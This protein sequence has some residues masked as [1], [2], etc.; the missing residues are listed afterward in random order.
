MKTFDVH[1]KAFRGVM[2]ALLILLAVLSATVAADFAASP[3]RFEKTIETLD[4]KKEDVMQLT[5][6]ASATSVMITMAPGDA[7]TPIAEKMAD[8]T[9]WFLLVLCAIYLEKYLVTI[10]GIVAFRVLIPVALAIFA[11]TL[12]WYSPRWRRLAMRL[13]ALALV[14][15][16][17][18]PMSTYVTNVIERTYHFSIDGTLESAESAQQEL[19]GITGSEESQAG[20]SGN[21]AGA[22]GQQG[23]QGQGSSQGSSSQGS[24]SIFDWIS[25]LPSELMESASQGIQNITEM[26]QRMVEQLQNVLNNFLESLAVM[27]ITSCV[28]PLLVLFFFISLMKMIFGGRFGAPM[29]VMIVDPRMEARER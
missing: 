22:Q 6:A 29:P 12:V 16:L 5:A 23:Q 13:V 3:E 14:L 28:I 20:T 21:G 26:P 19:Q 4:N 1:S 9:Q 7:A 15:Y 2:A 17:V 27:L 10:T 11:L 24:N 8:M 18:I 25:G